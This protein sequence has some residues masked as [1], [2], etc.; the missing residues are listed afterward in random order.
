MGKQARQG[1]G[2]L[3]KEETTDVAFKKE[4]GK[5]A[6]T[7]GAVIGQFR[8]SGEQMN[9]DVSKEFAETV[10]A[11]EHEASDRINRHRV[12]RQYQSAIKAYFSSV[13]RAIGKSQP[14]DAAKPDGRGAEPQQPPTPEDR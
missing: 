13:Q 6:T 1:R 9:G 8:V 14:A 7:K 11:A 12:P 5:V 10:V 2:G 3:A 4:R